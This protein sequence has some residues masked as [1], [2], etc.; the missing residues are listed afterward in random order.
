[1]AIKRLGNVPGGTGLPSQTGNSGKILVTDGTTASWSNPAVTLIGTIAGSGTISFTSI[2]QTY[3]HLRIHISFDMA[4][5]TT[6]YLNVNNS[7]MSF[8][9]GHLRY[10]STSAIVGVQGSSNSSPEFGYYA[11]SS[12]T[13]STMDILIPG[14]SNSNPKGISVVSAG[15]GNLNGFAG[16]GFSSSSTSSISSI[17]ISSGINRY[18]ASLYGWY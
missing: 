15:F 12:T 4:T 18:E 2:P 13:G 6:V 5:Q 11:G 3:R 1:M 7:A 16:H 17:S 14:Y 9:Y 8:N 10:S